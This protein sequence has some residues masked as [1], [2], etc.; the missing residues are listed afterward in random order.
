MCLKRQETALTL[1]E[2]KPFSQLQ[3][4][5][6]C[7]GITTSERSTVR[8]SSVLTA[9][10]RHLRIR[11]CSRNVFAISVS[12][13]GG[14]I[15]TRASHTFACCRPFLSANLRSGRLAQFSDRLRY[16][17]RGKVRYRSHERLRNWIA[18]PLNPDGEINLSRLIRCF[19]RP[20]HLHAYVEEHV[21]RFNER[22]DS[23]KK[24][25]ATA[26]KKTDGKHLIYR[27]LTTR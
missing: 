25:F 22:E 7:Y 20:K 26:V 5:A 11:R 24:R 16:C 9:A 2:S 12:N 1:V 15:E 4:E 3:N 8:T 6:G 18:V 21:F 17:R 27:E 14:S 19:P 13:S 23:D 10:C